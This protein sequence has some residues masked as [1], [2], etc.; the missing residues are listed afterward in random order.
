MFNRSISEVFWFSYLH[1]V[2]MGAE[3]HTCYRKQCFLCAD[4]HAL[5]T[6]YA[7]TVLSSTLDWII[8][9]CK[10]ETGHFQSPALCS[11]CFKVWRTHRSLVKKTMSK[12]KNKTE[13]HQNIKPNPPQARSQAAAGC[14]SPLLGFCCHPVAARPRHP[15]LAPARLRGAPKISSRVFPLSSQ[16]SRWPAV[17]SAWFAATSLGVISAWWTSGT[18]STTGGSCTRWRRGRGSWCRE[19]GSP[20]PETGSPATVRNAKL[21]A[22]TKF[23]TLNVWSVFYVWTA[24]AP[25]VPA[26]GFQLDVTSRGWFESWLQL[27][28]VTMSRECSVL[29][30]YSFAPEQLQQTHTQGLCRK[31]LPFFP[32]FFFL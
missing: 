29:E 7:I 3:C 10:V 23:S 18:S 31:Q 9:H 14:A 4:L 15:V 26:L 12:K 20:G 28:Y 32:Y 25:A 13:A 16:G 30:E 6:E 24:L 19:G 1:S 5:R 2:S 17:P 27:H 21:A 11:E 22:E 8:S